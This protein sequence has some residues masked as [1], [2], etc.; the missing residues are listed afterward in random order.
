MSRRHDA[1]SSVQIS[2]CFHHN[3]TVTLSFFLTFAH[4]MHKN[5]QHENVKYSNPN[6]S[7]WLC[8]KVF[9]S[10]PSHRA[11][12]E[13]ECLLIEELKP[14]HSGFWAHFRMSVGELEALLPMLASHLRRLSSS[15]VLIVQ[16]LV[17]NQQLEKYLVVCNVFTFL[18]F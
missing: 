17:S 2:I 18:R 14:D 6:S 16:A 13:W 9:G 1:A 15:V 8:V 7:Y 12:T 3:L 11:G 4:Q 5:T 10:T